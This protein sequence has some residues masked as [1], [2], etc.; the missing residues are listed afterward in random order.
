[1]VGVLAI[2][3]V[4]LFDW[5]LLIISMVHCTWQSI[6]RCSSFTYRSSTSSTLTEQSNSE[7]VSFGMSGRAWQDVSVVI[8][9]SPRARGQY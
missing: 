7:D 5:D 8:C 4:H 2:T 1:M 9:A 6:L 3:D